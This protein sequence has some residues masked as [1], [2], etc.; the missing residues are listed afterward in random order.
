VAYFGNFPATLSITGALID[1]SAMDVALT[2]GGSGP[3][4]A[5]FA[6][7]GR[8]VL[9]GATLNIH[10]N[11][12]QNLHAGETFDILDFAPGALR[13]HFASLTDGTHFGDAH[14]LDLGNGY[15]LDAVYDNDAG[16]VQ[17]VVTTVASEQPAA[18]HDLGLF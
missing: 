16:H 12:P 13:G 1:K 11:D 10:I 14:H 4:C 6:V 5:A 18:W 3:A 17:L 8:V 9:K 15:A 2:A 7:D